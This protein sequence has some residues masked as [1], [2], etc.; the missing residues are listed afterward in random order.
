MPWDKQIR[1]IVIEEW[2]KSNKSPTAA[3]KNWQAK[4][5]LDRNLKRV[6]NVKTKTARSDAATA[7]VLQSVNSKRSQRLRCSLP[8]VT[9]AVKE[10]GL[11]ISSGTVYK[12]MKCDLKFKKYTVRKTQF[13]RETD[14]DKRLTRCI[15]FVEWGLGNAQLLFIIFT[16][17]CKFTLDGYIQNKNV[18]W[19][20]T[21]KDD[22]P[23]VVRTKGKEVY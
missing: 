4:S 1:K 21:S 13:L 18:Y 9:F 14:Y 16:D 20:A 6:R 10:Q 5:V 19:W 11:E 2:L 8:S 17:E 3:R 7:I 23:K 12:I 22:I 15:E